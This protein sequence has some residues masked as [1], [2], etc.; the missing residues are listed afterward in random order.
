MSQ[1]NQQLHNVITNLHALADSLQV[2]A[3]T[4]ASEDQEAIG[5]QWFH[6]TIQ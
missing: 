6:L 2:L 5:T 4:M 3:D 1:P